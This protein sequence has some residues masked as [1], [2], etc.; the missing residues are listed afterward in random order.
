MRCAIAGAGTFPAVASA[1]AP[2]SNWRRRVSHRLPPRRKV[3][4]VVPCLVFSDYRRV[5][6]GVRSSSREATGSRRLEVVEDPDNSDRS[7]DAAPA[8]HFRRRRGFGAGGGRGGICIRRGWAFA[9]VDRPP[10]RTDPSFGRSI[11]HGRPH[12]NCCLGAIVRHHRAE[13][14]TSRSPG[15]PT[16][17]PTCGR[18]LNELREGG[19]SQEQLAPIEG[20]AVQLEANLTAL[21][22]DVRLRLDLMAESGDLM[23]GPVP[24]QRRDTAASGAH[25]SRLRQPARSSRKLFASAGQAPVLRGT[26][27]AF[28]HN[29][30]A[31]RRPVQKVQQQALDVADT[32]AQAAVSEQK[33]RLQIL[34]FQLRRTISDLEKGS[35]ASTRNYARCSWRRSTSSRPWPR[36]EFD[37]Q[38][39]QHELC[40]DRRYRPASGRERHPLER[41]HRSRPK[42]RG[43]DQAR[44]ARG[45]RLG[46]SHPAAE[47]DGD[48]RAARARFRR[49]R[50]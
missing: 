40:A 7:W 23:T 49:C 14:R 47:H 19:I 16:N 9:R 38:L 22:A 10:C 24:Y 12:R 34:A 21:D 11:A 36:A 6:H 2:S 4:Q 31:G 3:R 8:R 35:Q 48:Q 27:P 32:L 41:I 15:S 26:R 17:R 33:Q 46:S 18:S 25:I 29:R 13:A 50:F 39:R 5:R 1:V 43:T 28:A 20:Y 44:G 37:P 42:A 45:D 30:S